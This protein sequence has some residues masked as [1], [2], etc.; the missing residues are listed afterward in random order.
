MTRLPIARL[1]RH[2]SPYTFRDRSYLLSGLP[3]ANSG[4]LGLSLAPSLVCRVRA[5]LVSNAFCL[6]RKGF[7]FEQQ[8]KSL[9]TGLA[10][11]RHVISQAEIRRRPPKLAHGRSD[12]SYR[13][14]QSFCP[15]L[16]PSRRDTHDRTASCVLHLDFFLVC[17]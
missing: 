3:R 6:L 4:C 14:F 17:C 7:S 12:R 10:G 2:R 1:T 16:G 13:R 9:E 8:Q 11:M 15:D 5:S